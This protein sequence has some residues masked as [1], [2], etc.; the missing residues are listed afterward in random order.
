[1]VKQMRILINQLLSGLVVLLISIYMKSGYLCGGIRGI[2]KLI[3]VAVFSMAAGVIMP[4]NTHFVLL[5]LLFHAYVDFECMQ[6]F[7]IWTYI[8][9]AV[10]VILYILCGIPD[11]LTTIILILIF[12]G[13][14]CFV[15][16]AFQPA[17]G[18]IFFLLVIY[19]A[20]ER[21]DIKRYFLLLFMATGCSF[22]FWIAVKNIRR[23]IAG[24]KTL[25]SVRALVP[26]ILFG[27]LL[28]CVMDF[29]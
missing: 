6:V 23:L 9:L 8:G 27:Y 18:E 3:V 20:A 10:E 11:S 2:F 15:F 26:D 4:I 13:I 29:L 19:A 22:V 17:D 7:C 24:E 28:I 25:S 14:C 12:L 21:Y 16:H 5:I 1:M